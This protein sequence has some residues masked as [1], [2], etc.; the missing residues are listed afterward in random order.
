[1][2]G[3]PG[4]PKT[5]EQKEKASQAI[6]G[7]WAIKH[8]FSV[9]GLTPAIIDLYYNH[10]LPTKQIALKLGISKTSVKRLLK[11]AGYKLRTASDATKLAY[12]L[13][14][15]NLCSYERTPGI[16]QKIANSLKQYN[17]DHPNPNLG[18]H[19]TEETKAKL[20]GRHH[21]A[22]ARAKM[23]VMAKARP[24]IYGRHHS[25]ET[26]AKL[27]EKA[28]SRWQ[29]PIYQAKMMATQPL[30]AQKISAT[31]KINWQ[32]PEYRA[33]VIPAC[34]KS[35]R[36]TDLEAKLI[37]LIEK[38]NLPYKYTGDGTFTIGR[39]N[40]DFVNINGAKIA[41]EV[42]GG[43]WHQNRKEPIRTEEGRRAILREYGWQLIVIWGDELKSIPEDKIVERIAAIEHH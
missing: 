36:P 28:L 20:R 26:K 17:V 33:K 30:R 25:E 29:D 10:Q 32:K 42:F 13:G 2:E 4:I 43:H 1:M 41:I 23:S 11:K 5:K 39:L 16:R 27:S 3:N 37:A 9:L 18:R 38:Y 6:A 8:G 24:R 34:L 7:A 40:P 14:R 35:R 21:S 19:H 15:A 12:R 31:Q 22:E